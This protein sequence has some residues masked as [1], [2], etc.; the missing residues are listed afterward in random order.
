MDLYEIVRILTDQKKELEKIDVKALCPRREESQFELDS[1]LAQ[2][3]IGVRRSGKSMLCL[4]ALVQ[5][6]KKFGY[7]DFDDENLEGLERSRNGSLS[8]YRYS[9]IGNI[10]RLQQL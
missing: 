2:V 9:C 5:S 1:P 6:G 8:S 3:V 4:K 7:V 10:L